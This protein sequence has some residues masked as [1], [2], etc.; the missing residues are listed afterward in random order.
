MDDIQSWWEV[1]S[2][3][4]FCSLFRAAFNLLDF[5]IE[6]LEEALLTDGAEDSGS[7]LLQELMVRLL[8]GCVPSAQGCISIFNYQMFL[9]RLFRQKCKEYGR[10]NP[11]NTDIDFQFLPLRSK[12]EILHALCD[13]RLDADDVQDLLKNLESDSLR[14]E[15]LGHD[16]GKSAY[17]YFYGTRLYREDYPKLKKGVQERKRKVRDD[18]RK[19]MRRKK[20]KGAAAAED[21][22]VV[23]CPSGGDEED[24]EEALFKSRTGDGAKWQVVCYS[25]GDWEALTERLHGSSSAEERALHRTLAEDFLPE[26]PRLFAEKERLQRKRLQENQP[27]RTSGRIEKLKKQQQKEAALVEDEDRLAMGKGIA[28]QG[29]VMMAKVL[30]ESF[31]QMENERLERIDSEDEGTREEERERLFQCY[32]AREERVTRAF[33]KSLSEI[34]SERIVLGAAAPI[35]DEHSS[36]SSLEEVGSGRRRKSP[37]V[38]R[39]DSKQGRSSSR[40]LSGSAGGKGEAAASRGDNGLPVGRQTNNSLSSAT[41]PI[42][43]QTSRRKLKT[44]QV[45]FRQSNEDLQTG[46]HKILERVKSHEDAWPFADPVDEEWAPRYYAVVRKP[47]HLRRME[48][49]LEAG[50]YLTFSH[51]KA[52]FMLIVENCRKYNGSDNEYTEMVENLREVFQR[53]ADRYLESDLSSEEGGA[54]VEFP[55]PAGA[56]PGS[57]PGAEGGA[58]GGEEEESEVVH[59]SPK[60]A[61]EEEVEEGEGGAVGDG[62]SGAKAGAGRRRK[63]GKGGTTAEGSKRSRSGRLWPRGVADDDDEEEEAERGAEAA[64]AESGGGKHGGSHRKRRKKGGGGGGGVVEEGVAVKEEGVGEKI[65]CSSVGTEEDGEADEEEEGGGAAVAAEVKA[66]KRDSAAGNKKGKSK[67]RKQAPGVV[68]NAAAINALAE[69][70]EQTLKD[71]NKWLDDTP[72][73]SEFSSASNSPSHVLNAEDF[74]H[75]GKGIESDYRRSLRLGDPPIVGDMVQPK[76]GNKKEVVPPPSGGALDKKGLRIDKR[77]PN[78][79]STTTAAVPKRTIIERLQPGKSKGNLLKQGRTNALETD[80]STGASGLVGTRSIVEVPSAKP[81]EATPKLSLGSVLRGDIAFGEVAKKESD[82]GVEEGEEEEKVVVPISG[83]ACKEKPEEEKAEVLESVKEEKITCPTPNLSAWFKAFGAPKGQGPRKKGPEE[84]KG[85][86]EDAERLTLQKSE[87]PKVPEDPKKPQQPEEDPGKGD[88]EP[89]SP[90][91]TPHSG[92]QRH[93][94]TGSSNVSDLSSAFSPDGVDPALSPRLVELPSH[95]PSSSIAAPPQAIPFPPVNG[96]IRV[97]FYQDTSQK[98]VGSVGS[99]GGGEEQSPTHTPPSLPHAPSAPL[100]SSSS[101]MQFYDTSKPLTDQYREVAARAQHQHPTMSPPLAHSSSPSPPRSVSPTMPKEYPTTTPSVIFST[102]SGGMPSSPTY[103]LPVIYPPVSS[104]VATLYGPPLSTTPSSPFPDSATSTSFPVKKRLYVGA[105]VS[106]TATGSTETQEVAGTSVLS[107][108][109]CSSPASRSSHHPLDQTA[110]GQRAPAGG[111]VLPS[112]PPP[113]VAQGGLA[114][115]P[116]AHLQSQSQPGFQGLP[117]PYHHHSE[118]TQPH[119]SEHAEKH[120]PLR[121]VLHHTHPTLSPEPRPSSPSRPVE[122]TVSYREVAEHQRRVLDLTGSVVVPPPPPSPASRTTKAKGAKKAKAAKGPSRPPAPSEGPSSGFQQFRKSPETVVAGLQPRQPSSA[123]EFTA[124]LAFDKDFP[125]RHHHHHYLPT[126]LPPGSGYY[127]DASGMVKSPPTAQQQAG[128]PPTVGSTLPSYP[129]PLSP[130]YPHHYHTT[131]SPPTHHHLDTKPQFAPSPSPPLA[132]PLSSSPPTSP[133]FHNHPPP[134]SPLPPLAGNNGPSSS[135]GSGPIVAFQQQQGGG[136]Q[137]R[138]GGTAGVGGLMM[139]TG[140]PAPFDPIYHHQ[141]QQHQYHHHHHHG[142]HLHGAPRG[143]ELLLLR[144]AAPSL[145]PPPSYPSTGGGYP[146]AFDAINRP[147]W[148]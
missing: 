31:A 72:R 135:G 22:D 17:W 11:F 71:I 61:A 75:V 38:K 121:S 128:S 109:V 34:P 50:D 100:P 14:V 137:P 13:F 8:A 70:T 12:V 97:G 99:S 73:F 133:S 29:M 93:V 35:E 30:E 63:R 48:E 81:L 64:V 92:R 65:V 102:V 146:H 110:M 44:S 106:S 45:R 57:L 107:A 43:I 87:E 5:D 36:G 86:Q 134:H 127:V 142:H 129:F 78:Q 132:P 91:A 124:G 141:Q 138:E 105:A 112:S 49:K 126:P 115:Y 119:H 140:G 104:S 33:L 96:T 118:L 10:D 20:K 24:E 148:L 25:E 4:H 27:R 85:V 66:R 69:A 80:G 88:P 89:P 26:I 83:S 79:G 51:F 62:G 84:M 90:S 60:E 125:P 54:V 116:H 122:P 37:R 123:F 58:V 15:P 7:S 18:K 77:K 130:H 19:R 47:M 68:R 28:G 131:T 59:S 67:P 94:S 113:Y 2:I 111:L 139:A 145:P 136:A 147:S 55:P 32:L 40:A 117:M 108:P 39:R 46:L 9:R 53:A 143:E 3:A 76:D 56:V 101:D 42:I 74:E 95:S 41:G 82:D 21:D 23:E 144:G 16:E 1:P 6:E 103:P 114:G 120:E 98:S 52:D